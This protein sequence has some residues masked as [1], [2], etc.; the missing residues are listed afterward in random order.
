MKKPIIAILSILT[1]IGLLFYFLGIKPDN[2][3]ERPF[4]VRFQNNKTIVKWKKNPSET[5]GYVIEY[6]I[7][8]DSVPTLRKAITSTTNNQ[9]AFRGIDIKIE[10]VTGVGCAFAKADVVVIEIVPYGDSTEADFDG[11]KTLNNYYSG[12]IIDN[13]MPVQSIENSLN[14]T[15]FPY[16]SIINTSAIFICHYYD[17]PVDFKSSPQ[18]LYSS[19]VI[20]KTAMGLNI[21]Q[22]ISTTSSSIIRSKITTNHLKHHYILARKL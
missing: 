12:P 18:I 5:K 21:S 4:K 2:Q 6:R 17:S 22:T 14:S 16:H 9:I 3:C 8:T 11:I 10:K 7:T 13:L 15:S 20:D 1:V 19:E